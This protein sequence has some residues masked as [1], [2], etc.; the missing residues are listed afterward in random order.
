MMV[1]DADGITMALTIDHEGTDWDR[2]HIDGSGCEGADW[3]GHDGDIIDWIDY[4][5]TDGYGS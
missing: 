4:E 3:I 5:G 2:F 1:R